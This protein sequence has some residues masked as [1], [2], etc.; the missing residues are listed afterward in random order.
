MTSLSPWLWLALPAYL[1]AGVAACGVKLLEDFSRSELEAYSRR[2]Q[3]NRFVD[4]VGRHDEVV[5]AAESLL[6]LSLPFAVMASMLACWPDDVPLVGL[7]RSRLFLAA[8]TTFFLLLLLVAWI[9]GAVKHV[10]PAPFLFHTWPLWLALEFLFWPLTWGAALIRAVAQRLSGQVPK[11]EADEE[12]AFEDEIR[13]IVSAGLRDGFLEEDAG[14]MIEG[15]MELGDA[16][17]A[18]IMTP[19]SDVDALDV[20][21]GW[22]EVL[23]FVIRVGRTRI[24]VYDQTLDRIVGVLYVKDLLPE[25]VRPESERRPLRKLLREARY[26]PKTLRL[27]ELLRDFLAARNHL[28]IVVDEYG[29][30]EGVVTIEDVLEEIVGEIVDESDEEEEEAIIPLD[31][32]TADA[33]GR[34]HV[35]ELNEQ[36]GLHLE[37]GDDFDSIGGLIVQR[38]GRIPLPGESLITDGVRLTVLKATSRRVDRVRIDWSGNHGEPITG[39]DRHGTS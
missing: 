32:S 11:N 31:A 9:P 25:I 12:E 29:G 13:S 15:V 8:G 37:E 35:G 30:V 6:L 38:L 5:W 10:A 20:R 21:L 33:A 17:V 24:P 34:T 4:I 2:R 14:E 39:V 28:A 1:L 16:D 36:L 26:A 19:R 23:Q 27:D 7:Q 22:H 18:D 3:S